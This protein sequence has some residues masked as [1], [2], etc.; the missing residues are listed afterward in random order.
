VTVIGYTR[1]SQGEGDALGLVAQETAIRAA[2][3]AARIEQEIASGGRA[4][5]REVL[6]RTLAHLRRGDTLVVTKVDRLCRSLRDFA[7][8]LE[9]ARK[10]GWNLVVTGDSF[11]LGTANGRAMAGMLAVF[12][13]WE[14]EIMGERIKEALAAKRATEGWDPRTIPDS[15]RRRVLRLK[16]QGL[17]QRAI[18]RKLGTHKETVRRIL[19]AR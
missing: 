7:S 15:F 16:A 5:N 10:R 11:D 12:A 8:I 19:A 3:P 9:D 1:R 2:Y 6:Q 13:Q 17:S 4:D 14:R 18:A